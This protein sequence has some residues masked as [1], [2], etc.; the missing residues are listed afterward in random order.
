MGAL[1][2]SGNEVTDLAR[3][4]GYSLGT[5]A[6][7]QM[8]DGQ[9]LPGGTGVRRAATNLF[10]RGQ[11][12]ATTDWNAAAAGTTPSVDA[13]VPAPFSPQSI[14]YA[15]D[16]SVA[17]QGAS[18][19]TATGQA[20]TAGTVGVGS[21]YFKGVAGQ[22]YTSNLVWVNTDASSTV[23][24]TL[25]FTATGGWQQIAPAA[26]AVAVGKT[27]DQLRILVQIN[28]T[29]TE[30]FWV[31]HAMLEKGQSVVAPYVATSGGSTATHAAG[32]VQADATLLTPAEGSIVIRA[33][34]G[35]PSASPPSTYHT[36]WG[37]GDNTNNEVSLFYNAGSGFRVER[38]ASGSGNSQVQAASFTANDTVTAAAAW[39]PT[40][41]KVSSGGAPFTA[42]ANTNVP[43]VSAALQEIGG[44]LTFNSAVKQLDSDVLWA[45]TFSTALTDD[46]F[47]TIAGLWDLT[48]Q[49]NRRLM[50]WDFPPTSLCTMTY[51]PRDNGSDFFAGAPG[52]PLLGG[53]R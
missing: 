16:G 23:G 18:P 38:Y 25:T 6:S 33:R 28:G 42:K 46:D 3:R 52:I 4:I 49:P 14:K 5:S 21:C 45:A 32:R 12:D 29:R 9:T 31:A 36:F 10:R 19:R 44:A 27:G 7:G 48:T 11:C 2:L 30:S 39:T 40:T 26:L 35:W 22:S 1:I 37:L 8:L 51:D 34:M 20:A 15:C 43:T 47:A 50:P 53:I 17:A 24:T 41:I 13:T